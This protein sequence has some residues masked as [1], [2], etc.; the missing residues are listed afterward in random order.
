MYEI[1]KYI[2]Q[3]YDRPKDNPTALARRVDYLLERDMFMCPPRGDDVRPK[4]LTGLNMTADERGC[5]T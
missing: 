5:R 3:L 2:S 1:R 4:Q